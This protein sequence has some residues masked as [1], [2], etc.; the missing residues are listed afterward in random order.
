MGEG[1]LPGV[2]KHVEDVALGF[3]RVEPLADVRGAERPVLLPVPLPPRLD[4]V[5]RVRPPRRGLRLLRVGRSGGAGTTASSEQRGAADEE[6]S[7]AAPVMDRGGGGRP[8]L[9][10]EWALEGPL[11]RQGHH[12]V[13][14]QRVGVGVVCE[15]AGQMHNPCLG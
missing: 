7:V 9:E 8:H 13:G 15:P 4:L 10:L 6:D 5:E 11:Q 2:G 3:R 12:R 14:E 1:N